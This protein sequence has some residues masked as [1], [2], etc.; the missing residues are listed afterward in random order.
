MNISSDEGMAPPTEDHQL[1]S[2]PEPPKQEQPQTIYHLWKIANEQAAGPDPLKSLA[3]IELI[4]KKKDEM[5]TGEQYL[6]VLRFAFQN[7]DAAALKWAAIKIQR[8]VDDRP[9]K[10]DDYYGVASEAQY[11]ACLDSPDTQAL[12]LWVASGTQGER[13]FIGKRLGGEFA[14]WMTTSKHS[15]FRERANFS[16]MFGISEEDRK[17]LEDETPSSIEVKIFP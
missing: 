17:S 13:I 14:V 3:T 11:S 2:S 6:E 1:G 12:E 9:N 15:G 10:A 4:S 16:R 5:T 7:H 8:A